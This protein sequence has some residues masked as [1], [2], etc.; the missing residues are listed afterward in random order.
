METSS[1]KCM[2]TDTVESFCGCISKSGPVYKAAQ[3]FCDRA[4]TDKS[5]TGEDL[6]RLKMEL[7]D[8]ECGQCC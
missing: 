6:T 1:Q 8:S 7:V 4:K 3:D 2:D 5:I